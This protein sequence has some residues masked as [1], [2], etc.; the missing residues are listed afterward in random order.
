MRQDML[1]SQGCTRALQSPNQQDIIQDKRANHLGII[2]HGNQGL[3][4]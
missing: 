3:G 1:N 2:L 4:K